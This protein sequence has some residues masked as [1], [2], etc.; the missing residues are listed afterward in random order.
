M[1]IMGYHQK[2]FRQPKN[3]KNIYVEPHKFRVWGIGQGKDY[4]CYICS[5]TQ[6]WCVGGPSL[7][8][9]PGV[10]SRCV[11]VSHCHHRIS[12]TG[13][14]QTP[15]PAPDSRVSP[16]PASHCPS[17]KISL[18]AHIN[19]MSTGIYLHFKSSRKVL[20][21]VFSFDKLN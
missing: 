3:N 12:A 4:S 1:G 20:S 6:C 9:T 17:N 5:S 18:A 2:I 11:H 19:I 14:H 13:Y 16:L 8:T 7:L 15:A 21:L 10:W